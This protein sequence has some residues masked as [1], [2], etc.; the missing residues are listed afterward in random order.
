MKVDPERTKHPTRRRRDQH[1]TNFEGSRFT[2][3]DTQGCKEADHSI[4]QRSQPTLVSK[5][6]VTYSLLV[7]GYLA[8]YMLTRAARS[9]TSRKSLLQPLDT[10]RALQPQPKVLP[11]MLRRLELLQ[12]VRH[13]A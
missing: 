6:D 2:L 4:S 5:V 12:Q 7:L 8:G 3:Q 10:L 9:R 13:G 1:R 11:S